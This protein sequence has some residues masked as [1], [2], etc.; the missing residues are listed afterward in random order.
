VSKIITIREDAFIQPPETIQHRITDS[1][2]KSTTNIRKM[3]A[4]MTWHIVV[5]WRHNFSKLVVTTGLPTGFPTIE[6]P[7][8]LPFMRKH[9]GKIVIKYLHRCV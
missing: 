5:P 7:D 3:M 9:R 2:T 1:T 6:H 4:D 8:Q